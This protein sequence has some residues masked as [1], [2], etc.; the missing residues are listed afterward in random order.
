MAKDSGGKIEE[1]VDLTV[2]F[3]EALD[4]IKKCG[5]SLE[6]VIVRVD[7]LYDRVTRLEAELGGLSD[8]MGNQ[9][10]TKVI[11]NR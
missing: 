11:L 4:E 3:R 5:E 8:R 2:Q 1:H 6:R 7:D 9:G 10:A